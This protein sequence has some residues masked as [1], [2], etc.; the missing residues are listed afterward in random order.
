MMRISRPC[1]LESTPATMITAWPKPRGPVKTG[2]LA[3]LKAVKP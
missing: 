1:N 2:I 3:M